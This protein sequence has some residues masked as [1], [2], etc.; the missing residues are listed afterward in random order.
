[1]ALNRKKKEVEDL[2]SQVEEEIEEDAKSF[3]KEKKEVNW[4]DTPIL[5]THSTLLDLAISGGR[6]YEGG[7]PCSI[8][9]EI[10]GPAGSGKTAVL[11]EVGADAQ[12][13]DGVIMYEDPE[14]RL[15]QEYARIYNIELNKKNYYQPET[16]SEVFNKVIEWYN[17][18]ENK[19]NK[20]KVALTD[21]LAAL[22]TE[23][24]LDTG[25]KMG[26][27][28]AKEFSA[29]FRKNA[30]MIANMLWLCSNQER[31]SDNGIVTPG[32][33]AIPYYASLRIRIRQVKKIEV[34]KKLQSGT[35]VSKVIGI[36]SE[37]HITKS[38]VDDPYRKA[39]IYIVFGYGIDDIRGNLQYLKDM[40]KETSYKIGGKSFLGMDQAI[41]FVE[42]ND[43]AEDLRQET[44]TM[45]H[46]IEELFKFNKERKR[47]R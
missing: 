47:R 12:E 24:E 8:L 2:A 25:D 32:G 36:E 15:D 30:R 19:K 11:S 37:C 6:V 33:K 10:H 22:T 42:E 21:S 17:D 9:C 5:S 7:I 18:E 28:R 31:E 1:M 38:T 40:K 4:K 13:K 3:L 27:R 43:K 44:I 29:G 26:M 16:V 46:E 23:M 14:S 34:D 20:I 45:W 39:P 35:K 41:N